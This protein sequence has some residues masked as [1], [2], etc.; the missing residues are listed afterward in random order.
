MP[1]NTF[2]GKNLDSIS[3]LSKKNHQIWMPSKCFGVKIWTAFPPSL[4]MKISRVEC[5]HK[6]PGKMW[7]ASLHFYKK[8]QPESSACKIFGVGQHFPLFFLLKKW[9]V[10]RIECPQKH[11]GQKILD[12]ISP[13]SNNQGRVP[14]NMFW[15]KNL[16]SISPFKK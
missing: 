16:D 10:S 12:S 7:T 6:F 15:C 14:A 11:P 9:K 8:K 3:P 4:K 5:P 2:W 1:S 13:L